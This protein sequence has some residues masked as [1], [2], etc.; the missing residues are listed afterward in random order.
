LNFFAKKKY[1][2]ALADFQTALT[3]PDNLRAQ[4]GRNSRQVQLAYWTGCAFSALGEKD[5]ALKSWNEVIGSATLNNRIPGSAG[6]GGR[7]FGNNS[8]EQKYFITL[9]KKKL[10]AKEDVETV[11]REMASNK[12]NSASNA[13]G[14]E[15]D[16]QFVNAARLPSRDNL[17]TPHYIT[18]LGYA[19]LG[20]KAKALE[21]FNAALVLSPDF[22]NAKIAINTLDLNK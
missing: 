1:K 5:K 14:S 9:A 16:P 2:E 12:Q 4:Q 22:L 13:T 15:G 10:D 3:P 20:N 7:G 17:A 6:G 11:F 19:G 21:E 8:Q 18:G